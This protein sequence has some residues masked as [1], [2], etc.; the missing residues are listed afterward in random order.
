MKDVEKRVW[1]KTDDAGAPDLSRV[2]Y[3][4]VVTLGEYRR[5]SNA[6]GYGT[7]Y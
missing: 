5:E 7:F 6:G 1:R 4:Q 2:K 3:L